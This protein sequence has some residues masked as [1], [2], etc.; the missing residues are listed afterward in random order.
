VFFDPRLR[1]EHRLAQIEFGGDRLH[2]GR[3]HA[4]CTQHHSQRIAGQGGIGEH[5]ENEILVHDAASC[6]WFPTRMAAS[7]AR[8]LFGN[9]AHFA[10]QGT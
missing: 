5:I 4:V 6:F 8:T 1:N 7:L 10:K 2:P 9:R 3:L